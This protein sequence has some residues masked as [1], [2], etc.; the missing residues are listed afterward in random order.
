MKSTQRDKTLYYSMAVGEKL[1][2]HLEAYLALISFY[3]FST[4]N[5]TIRLYTDSPEYYQSLESDR[6]QIEDLPADQLNSWI[7]GGPVGT[8]PYFFRSKLCLATEL[9][10]EHDGHTIWFDTDCV[11]VAPLTLLGDRLNQ[12]VALMHQAEDPFSKGDTK[13]ERTYWNIL[14]KNTYSGIK[15]TVNSRQWNSGIIGI[16]QGEKNRVLKALEVLDAMMAEQVPGRTLEQ[17][18]A[19]L[20]LDG[21]GALESCEETIFHYWANK[22]VW[23]EYATGFLFKALNTHGS[24]EQA[25]EIYCKAVAENQLP[26]IRATRL[27]RA[28][29]H[30]KKWRKRLGL[31]APCEK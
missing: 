19:G 3:S 25:S 23:H 29:R 26:P 22:P 31:L 6:I 10:E 1:S 14:K 28:E 30:R 12:G 27:S 15:A 16:P 18:A 21:T 11:A 9:S 17:V 7:N 24:I 20:A 5:D 2:Y 13:A 4:E 8:R